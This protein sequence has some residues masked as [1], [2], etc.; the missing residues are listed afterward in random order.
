MNWFSMVITG[1]DL[2]LA[3]RTAESLESDTTTLGSNFA[4]ALRL[5]RDLA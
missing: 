1:K 3:A 4:Y 5:E 2:D